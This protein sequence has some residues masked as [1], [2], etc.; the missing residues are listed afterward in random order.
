MTVSSDPTFNVGLGWKPKMGA[1]G[2]LIKPSLVFDYVDITSVS[3]SQDFEEESWLTHTRFGAEIELLK[4]LKFRAGLN[5]GYITAGAGFDIMNCI[6]MD[7]AYYWKEMGS[8][9]GVKPVDVCTVRFS[10][11]H[12]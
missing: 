2:R 11:L 1:L 7:V 10:I 3:S 12:E 4:F 5:Q 6:H 8:S 9:L